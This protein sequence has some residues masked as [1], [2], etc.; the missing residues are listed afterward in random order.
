MTRLSALAKPECE[1]SLAG[2]SVC[3]QILHSVSQPTARGSRYLRNSSR[4]E[5]SCAIVPHNS[6]CQKGTLHPILWQNLK[7][8]LNGLSEGSR[9]RELFP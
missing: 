4:A 6:S 7:E 9:M 8:L 2:V 3:G 1:L 5:R